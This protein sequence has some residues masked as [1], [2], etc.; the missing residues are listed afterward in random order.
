MMTQAPL[1]RVRPILGVAVPILALTMFASIGRSPAAPPESI[2]TPEEQLG[3]LLFF[4][5]KLS[6][7]PGQAC[8]SC[9]SPSAGYTG[10]NAS[11]NA[12]G[13]VMPGAIHTRFGDRKPPSSAYAA[14]S[15]SFHRD[16]TSGQYFGGLTWDGRANDLPTQARVPLLNPVEMNNAR[17]QD[18]V[19]KVRK[20]SYAPLFDQ[21]FGAGSLHF[22]NP[23]DSL[24]LIAY[25]LAA[26]Q[27]SA[28]F[29]PFSSRY[30][31]Y[32]AGQPMLTDSEL[33]GLSLFEGRG[34]CASCHPNRPSADGT[35]PI[36]TNFS[37]ENLGV[38]RNPQNPTYRM[39]RPFNPQGKK[40]VDLG[41]GP[42][43]GDPSQNG[44]VKVPT[45]RNVDKRPSPSFVKAYMH[46]GIF[47][48]LK[49]VVHF[50]NARDVEGLAADVPA[51]VDD[52]NV[53]HL[54]LTDAEENDIVAFLKALTDQD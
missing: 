43:I 6:N 28:E 42:I 1:N 23:D 31:A 48:S 51:N 8:A 41:L 22:R 26:Y 30:D 27:S 53:G 9:H 46:N 25:A 37:Y 38:P 10:P 34:R 45:L 32:L 16:L 49:D 54:G 12:A 4:D 19:A 18:V 24:H 15:P 52:L 21:V 33:R 13:A 44:K 47:K 3:K 36:F 11:I 40:F 35:P 14:F 5:P 7:P 20:A 50:H 17:P 29:N 39:A 2:L